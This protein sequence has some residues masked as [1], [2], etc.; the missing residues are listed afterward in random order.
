MHLQVKAELVSADGRVA[1][2]ASRPCT[3]TYRSPLVRMLRQD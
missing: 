2:S 3:V 1:A